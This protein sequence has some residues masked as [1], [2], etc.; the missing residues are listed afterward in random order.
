MDYLLLLSDEEYQA[1][2]KNGHPTPYTFE[3][4]GE[5]QAIFY[6]GAKHSR[7]P[8]DDQWG[9][10]EVYWKQFLDATSGKRT[11]FLEGPGGFEVFGLARE[12]I[13][14]RFGEAGLLISMAKPQNIPFVWPDL[15]IQE[16]AKQLEQQFDLDLVNY[17]IFVRSAG[18]WLK[19]GAKGTFNEVVDKAVISTAQRISGAPAELNFY[20]STHKRIFGRELVLSEQETLIRAAAPVY[21]DSV[22]NDI[23]RASSRLRNQ[24][25]V[26]EI[27]RYWLGG[28]S[29]FVLLGSGH[30]VVQEMALKNSL[31]TN[32]KP[33]NS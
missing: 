9:K 33:L 4:F 5:K 29:I 17:F 8:K 26:S 15:S 14:K 21:H 28:N 2:F 3:I 23:A 7:N 19:A 10:L 12:E 11:V 24:H 20:A 31:G 22:I 16:E 18:A 13:I 30:A 32:R 27:E 6:F 25:I 1:R